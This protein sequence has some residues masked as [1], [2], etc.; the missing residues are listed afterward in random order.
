MYIEKVDKSRSKTINH[1][2]FIFIKKEKKK[3]KKTYSK[4]K[5]IENICQI[6]TS[7]CAFTLA[8]MTIFVHRRYGWMVT[9]A[10][11][12]AIVAA[13]L[14]AVG[15]FGAVPPFSTPSIWIC[16]FASISLDFIHEWSTC[17]VVLAFVAGGHKQ[18]VWKACA[19]LLLM[20]AVIDIP[21]NIALVSDQKYIRLESGQ[22][23]YGWRP[24]D[25][26]LDSYCFLLKPVLIH[27]VP[28]L[29]GALFIQRRGGPSFMWGTVCV[30]RAMEYALQMSLN[31][32][33]IY[34]ADVYISR[35]T[36]FWVNRTVYGLFALRNL[37]IIF[38]F[39]FCRK[40]AI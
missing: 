18:I 21:K 2:S 7:S 6:V 39:I 29:L 20:L 33:L 15:M 12:D 9:R 38:D 17:I 24:S 1:L 19:F 4:M 3:R 34:S 8:I 31:A 32:Q 37:P 13:H 28:A 25:I 11:A 14:F 5:N 26:L 36:D 23:R 22:C 40:K 30:M 27:I 35:D 10:V 16:R